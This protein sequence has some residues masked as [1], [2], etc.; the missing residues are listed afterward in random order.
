[1]AEIAM[2]REKFK[3]LIVLLADACADDDNFG[4]VRLSKLLFF[5][6]S[7]AYRHLGEPITGARYQRLPL[8]PAPRALLPVRAELE[9]EGSVEVEY[10]GEPPRRRRVTVARR[11]VDRSLFSADE[12]EIIGQVVRVLEGMTAGEV[13]ELSHEESP[14]WQL[15]DPNDD[16]PF[17]ASLISTELPSAQV[18]NR[19]RELA[20]EYGW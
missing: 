11:N 6:D 4:D 20:A 9:D 16:I 18:T 13:S 12:L 14:G 2:D 15:A 8:G 17:E 10:R 5:A 3:E 1:M 19:G 7:L